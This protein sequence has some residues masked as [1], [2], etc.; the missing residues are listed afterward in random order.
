M[1]GGD[2]IVVAMV[3]FAGLVVGG[4]L[5]FAFRDH[6]FRLISREWERLASPD[7]RR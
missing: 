4:L 5:G 7:E 2:L 3:G 6:V 1:S